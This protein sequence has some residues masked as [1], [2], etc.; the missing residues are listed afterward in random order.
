MTEKKPLLIV[1]FTFLVVSLLASLGGLYYF[2]TKYRA[3]GTVN[4]TIEK[5]EYRDLVHD[6]LVQIDEME[7][8]LESSDGE[9]ENLGE[10]REF[11]VD[12]ILMKDFI[13][14]FKEKYGKQH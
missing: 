10:I 5:E 12:G 13:E 7:P 11:D 14:L 6:L 8:T 2:F 3:L 1:L 9:D 4:Q